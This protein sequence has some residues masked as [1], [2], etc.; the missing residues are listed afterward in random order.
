MVRSDVMKYQDSVTSTGFCG[1]CRG[2][3]SGDACFAPAGQNCA[4]VGFVALTCNLY[5]RVNHARSS[6]LRPSNHASSPAKSDGSKHL[7]THLLENHIKLQRVRFIYYGWQGDGGAGLFGP[8]RAW[9]ARDKFVGKSAGPNRSEVA[10][11]RGA[12]NALRNHALTGPIRNKSVLV[13]R[14]MKEYE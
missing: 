4:R 13:I 12:T 10:P 8:E 6:P 14:T 2:M 7:I 11:R 1:S 3:V 9:I 5:P